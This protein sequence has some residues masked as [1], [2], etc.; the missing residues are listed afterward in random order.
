MQIFSAGRTNERHQPKVVQEVLAD[1]K[2]TNTF[3]FQDSHWSILF[4]MVIVIRIEAQK[5]PGT[6]S[7]LS[8]NP[9]LGSQHVSLQGEARADSHIIRLP[10]GHD[11]MDL[12]TR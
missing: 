9:H 10:A 3:L 4:W 11:C 2:S 6:I 8:T 1:L 12:S 5:R 7:S